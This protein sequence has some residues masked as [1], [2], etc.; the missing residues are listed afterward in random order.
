MVDSSV[1]L[2]CYDPSD[3]RSLILI[4]IIP[5]EQTRKIAKNEILSSLIMPYQMKLECL[6]G[7]I[8]ELEDMELTL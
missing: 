5:M 1:P 3:L 8:L 7:Y 2:I 4:Q 6:I